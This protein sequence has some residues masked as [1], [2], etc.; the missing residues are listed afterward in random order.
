MKRVRIIAALAVA[1]TVLSLPPAS[2]GQGQ[3]RMKLH[4]GPMNELEVDAAYHDPSDI[5]ARVD[6][7]RVIPVWL[8]VTNRSPQPVRL[9]YQDLSLDLGRAAGP[10]PLWPVDAAD[11]R[12]RLLR[13]GR[14]NSFVRFLAG[15][16]NDY[17]PDPF[18]QVL[19]DG[20]LGP[21]KSKRGYV[22]FM[23][24]DNVPF[25][26]FLALG[27]AAYK[28]ALLR[29]RAFEVRSPATESAQLWSTAWLS[30]KWDEIFRGPP[31]FRKS[32]ALLF[33]VS[34]YR[35]LERLSLVNDD[36]Q[37]M[38]TFLL[39]LGFHVVRVQ[40]ERLTMANVRSPQE[41]FAATLGPDDRLLVYF[42][43]HGFQ[44]D[45]SGRE[46]GYLALINARPGQVTPETHHRHGRLRRMD[47]KGAGQAPARAA[48]CVL[49][50]PGR[51]RS[52]SEAR[53][54][55]GGSAARTDAG[56][57]DVVPAF[58]PARPLSVDGWQQGSEGDREPDVERRPVH[59]RRRPGVER[60][61]RRPEGR[62]RHHARAVSVAAGLR[63]DGGAEGGPDAD[64]V[65]EGSESRCERRRVRVHPIPIGTNREPITIH[66][67]GITNA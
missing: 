6:G 64:A 67:S 21:G 56:S 13:D 51:G 24:P 33:G 61:C 35:Y 43:G 11:A 65:D 39:S 38:E 28:P 23:R 29:T 16:D 63:R 34:D 59:T 55:R 49:Q 4:L 62:V 50:R 30:Q 18:S 27:T 66:Q 5:D 9:D 46:R 19:P 25:T 1:T 53:D 52:G 31:P 12:A 20:L 48:R 3:F 57:Q 54:P 42:S 47:A 44:R 36:L 10:D 14:Y 7:T 32:Y 17:A 45:E 22:F 40:N 8:D 58:G 60:T 15:Q 41:Y 2:Y 26:G 37:K